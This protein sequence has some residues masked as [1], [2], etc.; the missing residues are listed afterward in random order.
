MTTK[1]IQRK[2]V[3]RVAAPRKTKPTALGF[4]I[5]IVLSILPAFFQK[6]VQTTDRSPASVKEAIKVH[7]LQTTQ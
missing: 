4:L 6:T 7:P 5:L 2:R 1:K 3:V